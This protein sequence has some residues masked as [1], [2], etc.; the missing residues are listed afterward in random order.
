MFIAMKDAWSRSF[1]SD[2]SVVEQS[3]GLYQDERG[4]TWIELVRESNNTAGSAIAAPKTSANG[5]GK[6]VA[7]FHTH[8]HEG[9]C[10]KVSSFSWEDINV[11]PL[12]RKGFCTYVRGGDCIYALCVD[13]PCALRRCWIP[14]IY[15]KYDRAQYEISRKGGDLQAQTEAAVLRTIRNCGVCFYRACRRAHAT[16]PD[17]FASLLTETREQAEGAQ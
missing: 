4:K 8:P 1:K 7:D 2:G 6:L 13:D 14:N 10:L 5:K 9:D 15:K 17:Q 12:N 16:N 11:L 3:G